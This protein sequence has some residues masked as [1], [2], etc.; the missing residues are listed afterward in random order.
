MFLRPSAKSCVFW[1]WDGVIAS[2]G[3]AW[4]KHIGNSMPL[5]HNHL[6]ESPWVGWVDNP[7]PYTSG[8]TPIYTY[9][10]A[11]PN[12]LISLC[13]KQSDVVAGD[14]MTWHHN[15]TLTSYCWLSISWYNL[16]CEIPNIEMCSRWNLENQNWQIL[17]DTPALRNVKNAHDCQNQSIQLSTK[18][19][20]SNETSMW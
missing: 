4:C 11:I 13:H 1:W 15:A 19:T 10:T 6:Y 5:S 12:D 17:T 18:D 8:P 14:L 2:V 9:H 7:F 3:C 20:V 16:F